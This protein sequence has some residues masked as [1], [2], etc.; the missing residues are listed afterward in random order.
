[1]SQEHRSALRNHVSRFVWLAVISLV[2]LSACSGSGATPADDSS[3]AEPRSLV[4]YSGRSESLVGPLIEQF[5]SD[6][7]IQVGVRWG[8]TA[9]L[10]ATLLEE[11]SNS[12]A[13]V[14]LAQDPGGLGAVEA[15]LAP[16]PDSIL[17]L[18]DARFRDSAGRWVGVSGRARVVVYNTDRLSQADLPGD[19]WGF[20]QPQWK[21]RI[22]WAP[23]NASFQTMITAMRVT[24]GEAETRRWLERILANDPKVY[25]KNTPIVAAVGAGEVDVGF[26]N[27]YYLYRFLKEEG[28]SFPAR[29]YFLSNGG[30]GALI[31]VSGAGRLASSQHQETAEAFITFLLSRQAQE[32]F[33]QQTYE[34][35]MA[36][37]VLPP[38][39]LPALE[40]L[41]APAVELSQLADLRGTLE[42]L[43][44]VGALP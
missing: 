7:G 5:Q 16:I 20:T 25:E 22:G 34:Y 24:W 21:G 17:N 35:P 44:D 37:G 13:D 42:L 39:D 27:H 23:T 38:A 8:T 4:V 19:L 32:Y 3:A 31:M 9:Q 10:A 30:P 26:V 18:V 12:P 2:A 29:N 6:T 1:M 15:L 28:P 41:Q 11:G 33:A 40:T 43:Q 14:F 36:Q